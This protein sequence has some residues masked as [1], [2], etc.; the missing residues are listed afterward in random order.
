MQ[1]IT[2]EI[3][4]T[5]M[6]KDDDVRRLGMIILAATFGVL[7]I[8]SA[9]APIDSAAL[10]S[11]YVTVKNNSKILQHLEGGIVKKLLVEE[12]S[13]VN[14]GDVLLEID[15]TQIKAQ[16]EIIQAQYVVAKSAE[17]R[18]L[19]EQ[20]KQPEVQYPEQLLEDQSERTQ[21]VIKAQNDIFFSRVSAREGE[22]LVLEQRIEQLNSK[23][24]GL[25]KQK[26]SNLQLSSSLKEELEELR[27]LLEE[28]F[29]DKRIIREKSRE[30][31]RVQSAIAELSASMAQAQIQIGETRLQI[32]QAEKESAK[33][34]ASEL[35]DTHAKVIDLSERLT[36][37]DDTL[38]RALMKAPISGKVLNLT[39]H[40]EGGVISPGA[41]VLNIVP[42]GGE[43]TV[44]ARVSPNDIDRVH[45]GFEA[46]I[47]FSAFSSKTTRT[48]Y[49]SIVRLSPDRIV[50]E[51]TGMAYY[52]AELQLLPESQ[53]DIAS[54]ELLPGM[55]AE[56]LI[57]TGERTF[58]Q[59]LAKPVT[60][61]FSRS[62]LEE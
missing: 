35:A 53:V 60:D 21:S 41:P 54:L 51:S 12:G 1:E 57:T 6:T 61:A 28:G 58:F 37:M 3:D 4:V 26:K 31:L 13:V 34:I 56:V 24:A 42:K 46:E 14:K 45:I 23:Y 20:A 22:R 5:A 25:K 17:A 48:L 8:W 18:L 44:V 62:F 55:P 38:S 16:R 49:G 2:N 11:G 7:G 15:D 59:Y 36:A 43:L 30:K 32:I 10:A 9:V 52:Q 29:A 27:A 19:A 47:R 50:D 39:V 40:T 33:E